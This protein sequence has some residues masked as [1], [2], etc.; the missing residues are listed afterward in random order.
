MQQ[1]EEISVETKVE[2]ECPSF[3]INNNRI[4][5]RIEHYTETYP[6]TPE[7]FKAGVTAMREK[8]ENIREEIMER[9]ACYDEYAQAIAAENGCKTKS[10]LDDKE[11]CTALNSRKGS[12]LKLAYNIERT[13]QNIRNEIENFEAH[14]SNTKDRRR[15]YTSLLHAIDLPHNMHI[16]LIRQYEENIVRGTHKNFGHNGRNPTEQKSAVLRFQQLMRGEYPL[17]S[18]RAAIQVAKEFGCSTSTVYR[19]KNKYTE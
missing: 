13:N 8:R 6:A 5:S 4:R 3:T 7:G 9:L 15:Y 1:D 11:S 10:S 17:G 19:W 16:M 12:T 14:N 2:V 18:S